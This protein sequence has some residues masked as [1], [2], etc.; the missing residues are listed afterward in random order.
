[1]STRPE[2]VITLGGQ[3]WDQLV[4]EA[5]SNAA[6]QTGERIVVNMGPQHPSTHGVLRLVLEIEGETVTEARCGVGYLHTGIEKNLEYRTWMQGVTFVTRMDYL[7]PF[8]NETVYCLGVE[9]L[10]GITEAIPE[11]ANVIRVMLMELNRISSHLVALATGG[12]EL[13]A[14]TA[15]FLGFREREEILK[16]FELITGLRMNHAYIRPGGLAADLPPDAV[17][18]VR[19]LLELLPGRLRDLEDLL[20]QNHIWRARNEG[21]GYLDLTGCMALGVTGP[22]LRSAGLPHD[23]RKSQPYCGY[24]NYEFD[25]IT[26]D[27]CDAYGRFMIRVKEMH[28][29]LKIVEQCLDRLRPGPVMIEDRKLA[30]P[31]DL[32]LG[33]DGLGNSPEHVARI[34]GRSMEGLIHHFKLVTE[35]IR[36]PPGQVYVAVESPRGELGVHMVSDGGTRPYR[37]HYRDPSFTNLQAVAAMAEG[38]MVADLIAALA[39]IDPVMGGVD[40]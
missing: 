30:W 1:M 17:P 33:P 4:A 38:G 32:K 34:M 5:R 2:T 13:G 6:D 37:V 15:M 22:V 16:V 27:R 21:V 35:G 24:E 25:V 40:R 8:F 10:L 9:K 29:S 11:R 19:E 26:D 12:M 36:V 39:S 7:S 20:S 3:D 31:A 23:L 18:R 14:M 28:E